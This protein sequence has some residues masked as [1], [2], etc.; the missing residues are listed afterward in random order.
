MSTNKLKIKNKQEQKKTY[1][2]IAIINQQL[3]FNLFIMILML[4][5]ILFTYHIYNIFI[6]LDLYIILFNI[7]KFSIKNIK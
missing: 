6:F 1:I 5:V 2:N 7:F 4:G 3:I